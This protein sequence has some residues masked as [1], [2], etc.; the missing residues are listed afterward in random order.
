MRA[1]LVK[2]RGWAL[3][4]TWGQIP[5]HLGLAVGPPVT[6]SLVTTQTA[7]RGGALGLVNSNLVLHGQVHPTLG[8][9]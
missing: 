3:Q 8:G 6:S 5:F 2:K 9:P 1:M 7:N 4:R